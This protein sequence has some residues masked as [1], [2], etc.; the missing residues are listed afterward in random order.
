MSANGSPLA[1]FGGARTTFGLEDGDAAAPLI[2]VA[3]RGGEAI[4]LSDNQSIAGLGRDAREEARGKLQGLQVP[5]LSVVASICVH[6][7]FKPHILMP[8]IYPEG[9]N[10]TLRLLLP[11]RNSYK[12]CCNRSRDWLA[13][14]W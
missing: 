9:A 12:N 7:T 8:R 1:I 4:D 2:Q 11:H 10:R 3:L 5:M 14:S 13:P 6:S